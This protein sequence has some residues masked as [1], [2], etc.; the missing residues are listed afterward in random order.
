V[1][2]WRGESGGQVSLADI[3]GPDYRSGLVAALDEVSPKLGKTISAYRVDHLPLDEMW[4][5]VAGTSEEVALYLAHT[6]AHTKQPA[7]VVGSITHA[8]RR[9][10]R[11][12][13]TRLSVCR[14]CSSDPPGARLSNCMPH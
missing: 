2:Y 8:G 12:D 9:Y 13:V 5:A 11:P 14:C 10:S 4:N 3:L 7:L 6:E 1:G